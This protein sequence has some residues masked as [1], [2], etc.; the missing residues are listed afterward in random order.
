MNFDIRQAVKATLK[1]STDADILSTINDAVSAPDEKV[2]PGLGVMFEIYWKN[3]SP[4]EKSTIAVKI[5]N[6]L[7]TLN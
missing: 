2:L 7:K 3:C 1:Q 4:N 5:A 6:D